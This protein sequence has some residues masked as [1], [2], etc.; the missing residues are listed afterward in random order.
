MRAARLQELE[1]MGAKLQTTARALP[2]GRDRDKILQEIGRFRAE[3]AAGAPLTWILMGLL[4]VLVGSVNR[5]TFLS[6]ETRNPRLVRLM[7]EGAN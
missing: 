6:T 2:S 4:P 5:R 3:I 1:E 7:K